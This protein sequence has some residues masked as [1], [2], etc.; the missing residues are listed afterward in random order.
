M[1]FLQAFILGLVEGLTE[2]IPVSSTAA[3]LLTDQFLQVENRLLF[4]SFTIFVQLGAMLAVLS[5]FLRQ[6]WQNKKIWKNLLL[7]LL[8]TAI[9]G[10]TFYPLVK[11]YLQDAS[12]L[13]G[14]VLII[15]AIVFTILDLLFR[16][17][18]SNRDDQD[19]NTHR[20]YLK[21]LEKAPWW[22]VMLIGLGQAIAMVPGVSRSGATIFTARALGFPQLVATQFSFILALPTIAAAS[23]LDLL[24]TFLTRAD[25]TYNVFNHPADLLL[26]LFGALIAFLTAYFTCNFFIKILGKKPFYVWAIIRILMGLTWLSFY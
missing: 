20:E 26:L 4:S 6:I 22:Q 8:P 18:Y 2:F 15:G 25:S 17:L 12:A 13:T 24:D 14:Y 16:R 10:F 21:P 5:L 1:T 11:D 7:A 19:D 3:L 9:L 23:G